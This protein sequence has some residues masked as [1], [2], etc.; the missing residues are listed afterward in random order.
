MAVWTKHGSF[1]IKLDTEEKAQ[2]NSLPSFV[3][4]SALFLLN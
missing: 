3:L 1:V 2:I 4:L